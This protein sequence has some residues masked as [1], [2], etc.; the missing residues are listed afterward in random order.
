M[1]AARYLNNDRRGYLLLGNIYYSQGKYKL[2]RLQYYK[3]VTLFPKD[4][5]FKFLLGRAHFKL[6][7]KAK[8]REYL[9]KALKENLAEPERSEARKMLAQL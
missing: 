3:G 7:E 5:E 8:A 2:A 6:D 1:A 4:A 9:Q